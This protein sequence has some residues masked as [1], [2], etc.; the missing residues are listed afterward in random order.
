MYFYRDYLRALTFIVIFWDAPVKLSCN[1][2]SEWELKV[3]TNK[4][5]RKMRG[6]TRATTSWLMLVLHLIGWWAARVLLD[7]SQSEVKQNQ[8]HPGFLL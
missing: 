6:K 4:C 1:L 2:K 7:Q 3:K 5:L 8:C